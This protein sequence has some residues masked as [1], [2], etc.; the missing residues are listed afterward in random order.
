MT[1]RKKLFLNTGMALLYQ[2]ITLVCGFVLPKFIIPHFGSAANGLISS[3]T[4]A[5]TIITLCE[6]GVGAVVQS[7]LYKPLADR[8][9]EGISKV[10][11]S[12]EHFFNKIVRLLIGYVIILCIVYPFIVKDGFSKGYI[13]SLVGILALC[14]FAQY[15]L[16]LTYRLLLNADQASYV[17]LGAHSLALIA[18]TG[19]TILLIKFGASVHI[20]KLGSAIAF[21]IQPIAIR[22]YVK[23]HYQLNL[24]MQ[25]TEDPLKQ[26]W[27]GLAQHI[28]SVVQ[29]NA[30]TVVLTVFSTLQNI[31]VYSVYYLIAHGIRQVIVSLNTGVKAMLGNMLAKNEMDTLDKTFSAVEF[32]FHTLVTL[33]FCVAGILIIPFV[34]IYTENFTD[35]EYIRPLFGV[36]M[37]FGQ[38]IYCLR[39]PYEMI[40]QAAGHYKQTQKSS[41]IE[42]TINITVAVGFVLLLGLE[43]VAI[44]TI[45]AMGYR[46]L[47]LV[48]YIRKN[49][50][51]RP[52]KQF[53]KHLL[54]DAISVCGMLCAT[55][56]IDIAPTNYY[57]WAG[58]AVA[59]SL[60]CG[61]VSC[62]INAIMY[63]K[64]LKYAMRVFLRRSRKENI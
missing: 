8:N 47:Y 34:S 44:S 54:V 22:L 41:I 42:A 32:T 6:C 33:L 3:I 29:G 37:V 23:K 7:A 36:L 18:N 13:I 15:Y 43:G 40:I 12:S 30:P 59:I 19:I 5:L 20:V 56:W 35:A 14:Y 1:R 28:A 60:I 48:L 4:Q 16:F 45:A 58:F 24:R 11:I 62:S 46:M 57:Q 2:G 51:N 61:M 21:L 63:K 39:I 9:M 64:E 53:L 26:K 49:I 10:V 55:C 25:L 38:A 50:L 27:N 52:I 17:Q 31:S